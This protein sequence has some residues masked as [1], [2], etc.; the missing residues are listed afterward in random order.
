MCE[1]AQVKVQVTSRVV[2]KAPAL[3]KPREAERPTFVMEQRA[4]T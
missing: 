1:W 4:C 2:G 3:R